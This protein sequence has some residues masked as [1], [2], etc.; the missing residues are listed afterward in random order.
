NVLRYVAEKPPKENVRTFKMKN[1]TQKPLVI[2][3]KGYTIPGCSC[4]RFGLDVESIKKV[5]KD[6]KA[7]PK[8]YP[9]DFIKNYNFDTQSTCS[10][11]TTQRGA[12]QNVVAYSY[13]HT[14]GKVNIE[15]QHFKKY[16]GQLHGRAR[17]I[18]DSYPDW[19]MR[20][21]HNVSE[22][23]EVG[24]KFLCKIYCVH[25][26]VDLCQVHNLPDLGDLVK[27][28]V[29]GRLWRFAVMGDPTV[30]LFLSRDSDSWILDREVAVVREWI[31]SGKGFHVIRDHPNHKAVMLA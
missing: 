7:R 2:A 15:S 4:V 22:D 1:E 26:H 18:H 28:G 31:S 9:A 16:L 14:E 29:V 17:V 8:L 11:F 27:R 30:S 6:A 21:Y 19:N 23:D 12:G 3:S 25:Q 5:V 24:N 13:Y 20:I 10:D